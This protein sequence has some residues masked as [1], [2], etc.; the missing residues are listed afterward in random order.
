MNTPHDRAGS[1]ARP[2]VR[3]LSSPISKP[4]LIHPYTILFDFSEIVLSWVTE[5]TK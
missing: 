2:T 3:R 5:L 1:I 4:K